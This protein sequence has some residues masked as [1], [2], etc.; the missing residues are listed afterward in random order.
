MSELKT[1]ND[2]NPQRREFQFQLYMFNLASLGS[3]AAYGAN[4]TGHPKI[5]LI[6]PLVSF[7]IC[8]LWIAFAFGA[9]EDRANRRLTTEK[10]FGIFFGFLANIISFVVFPAVLIY[11]YSLIKHCSF[12]LCWPFWLFPISSFVSYI[13]W[14]YFEYIKRRN[15]E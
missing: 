14:F 15:T 3:I 13:I 2:R 1:D 7:S 10:R 8:L 11:L 4:N 6:G 5:F 9:I 12:F